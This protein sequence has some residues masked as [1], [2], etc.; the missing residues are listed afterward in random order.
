[1][2][3]GDYR[4]LGEPVAVLQGC[5][6]GLIALWGEGCQKCIIRFRTVPINFEFS[7]IRKHF[8][9]INSFFELNPWEKI[10]F[11]YGND[12]IMLY[13]CI[14]GEEAK[15]LIKKY[16]KSILREGNVEFTEMWGL[17]EE[18]YHRVSENVGH[19][20]YY[21]LIIR[22]IEEMAHAPDNSDESSGSLELLQNL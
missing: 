7:A 12:I 19:P 5:L 13:R 1:M 3:A 8:S 11:S 9:F 18:L 4:H 10:S 2:G 21:E 6:L 17:D 15:K 20:L 22:P 14:I 16:K